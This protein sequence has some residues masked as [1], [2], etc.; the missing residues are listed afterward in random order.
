VAI[1]IR[2]GRRIRYRHSQLVALHAQFAEQLQAGERWQVIQQ[3]EAIAASRHPLM[4][5]RDAASGRRG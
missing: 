3:L 1:G 5:A 4:I 2:Q